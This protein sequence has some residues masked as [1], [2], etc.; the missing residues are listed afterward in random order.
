MAFT[1]DI[2][3]TDATELAISKIRFE[4]GDHVE[5]TGIRPDGTN[6]AD[7]EVSYWLTLEG[8]VIMRAVAAACET[9]ARVWSLVSDTTLG[10]HGESASQLSE[11]FAKRAETLRQEFGYGDS[12]RGGAFAVGTVPSDPSVTTGEYSV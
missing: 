3:S 12:T 1:Y 2:S 10:P 4:I 11:A 6:F 7:A 8:S 9:L 5:N